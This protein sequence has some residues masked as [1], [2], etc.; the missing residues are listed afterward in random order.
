MNDTVFQS[1]IRHD[2]V[3]ITNTITHGYIAAGRGVTKA[4]VVLVSSILGKQA[5]KGN[6][7]VGTVLGRGRITA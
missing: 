5:Q 7:G 6:G 4:G 2:Y 3:C 1:D